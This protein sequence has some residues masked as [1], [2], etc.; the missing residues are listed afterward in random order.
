MI[1]VQSIELFGVENF[2][3][4]SLSSSNSVFF[5]FLTDVV[6][7]L[8]EAGA[9][10]NVF[11]GG[12]NTPLQ[13]AVYGGSANCV[14]AMIDGGYFLNYFILCSVC[15]ECWCAFYRSSRPDLWYDSGCN[16]ECCHIIINMIK[17]LIAFIFNYNCVSIYVS[18]SFMGTTPCS[19]S[20][21]TFCS[22]LL[23]TE[24]STALF[25]F[26]PPHPLSHVVHMRHVKDLC[27]AVRST[28][29]GPRKR[30]A[31]RDGTY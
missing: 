10:V 6:K 11:D 28:A 15:H 17:P 22:G 4:L 20:K 30:Q 14:Q 25:P 29:D 7:L 2:Y 24:F 23:L 19:G 13:H 8:L 5:T 1:N 12:N 21:L 26:Q 31:L 3:A 9:D 27:H 16:D 18:I